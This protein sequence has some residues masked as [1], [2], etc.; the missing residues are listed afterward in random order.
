MARKA[1]KV[2]TAP[3]RGLAKKKIVV[4]RKAHRTSQGLKHAPLNKHKRRAWKRYRGQGRP[5]Q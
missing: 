1:P 5:R 4:T 2:D 3:V